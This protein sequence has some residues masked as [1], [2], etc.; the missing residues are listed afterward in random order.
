MVLRKS[1]EQFRNEM[2]H[3]TVLEIRGGHHWIFVSNRDQVL[4]AV[5]K[6]LLAS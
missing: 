4:A 5:R 6:F 3:G 2:P 1:R